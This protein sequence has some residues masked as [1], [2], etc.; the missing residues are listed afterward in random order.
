MRRDG[1]VFLV[2][3]RDARRLRAGARKEVGRRAVDLDRAGVGLDQAGEHL[4]QRALAGAV[5]AEQRHHLAGA[6]LEVD[7][8]ERL[9]VAVALGQAADQKA[10][11]CRP[12]LRL[13]DALAEPVV[14]S[15]G[16]LAGADLVCRCSPR[17]WSWRRLR[18]RSPGRA[19]C[20]CTWRA[21]VGSIAGALGLDLH[22]DHVALDLAVGDELGRGA[23]RERAFDRGRLDAGAEGL[24]VLHRVERARAV[25][26]DDPDVLARA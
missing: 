13:A 14:H 5:L 18:R 24:A 25:A 1:A 12:R 2:D 9:D 11:P 4:D 8:G 26:G 19:A 15:V 17:S 23:D 10:R 21:G 20:S 3:D 22:L 6:E 7:L 16:R